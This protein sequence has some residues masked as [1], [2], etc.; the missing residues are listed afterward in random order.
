MHKTFEEIMNP[1]VLN[2]REL[3]YNR[4]IGTVLEILNNPY[5]TDRERVSAL[6]D[7]Q[8]DLSYSHIILPK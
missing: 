3:E 7:I 8:E 6:N 5:T 4:L 1:P 2:E